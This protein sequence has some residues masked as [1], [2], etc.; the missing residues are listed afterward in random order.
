[1]QVVESG[2]TNT[3]AKIWIVIPTYWTREMKTGGFDHPTPVNGNS[4][5]PRL[6][7]SLSHQTETEFKVLII[8]GGVDQK[9]LP[10]ASAAV[11]Q[12]IHEYH[13]QLDITNCDYST[14]IK[15]RKRYNLP[16]RAFNLTSYA[17]IRNLQLLFPNMAGAE[18]VVA[19]DDDEIVIPHYVY[20]AVDEISKLVNG[21]RILGLAGPYENENGE[22]G[23]V[24]VKETGNIFLDKNRIMNAGMQKLVGNGAKVVPSPQVFGGN[25]IFHLDLFKRVGFDPGITRGEDMDYMINSH[26]EGFP[27]YM[28]NDLRITHLPPKQYGVPAYAKLKQDV[29]RFI[30]ERAKVQLY[31]IKPGQFEPYPGRF[32]HQDLDTHAL[33]A[34]KKYDTQEKSAT[35][36]SP[37]EILAEAYRHVEQALPVYET[38]RTDWLGWMEQT[39]GR[40]IE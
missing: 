10:L 31:Q 15:V 19:L 21:Q 30:Y 16:D 26:I 27:W 22:L 1:M 12:I 25:M 38:F 34:L 3:M 20:Q 35:H 8:A 14:V 13:D 9:V 17:G 11:D 2:N 18:L 5:L 40:A 6:L 24:E 28:A 32:L 33:N 39:R 29:L 36:G 7:N 23:L 4:T 37:E